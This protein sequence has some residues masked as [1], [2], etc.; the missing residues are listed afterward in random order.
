MIRQY[1]DV[2]FM[3][4]ELMLTDAFRLYKGDSGILVSVKVEKQYYRN[5]KLVS[6]N[7]IELG[8][9][10]RAI[11]RKAQS[12]CPLEDDGIEDPVYCSDIALI[13]EGRLDILI[14]AEAIDETSEMGIYQ[15]QIQL[16]GGI[17]EDLTRPRLTLEPFEFEACDLISEDME[18]EE[19]V[20]DDEYKEATADESMVDLAMVM[21]EEEDEDVFDE[22]GN[23]NPTVWS[24]GMLI[25]SNKLNKMEGAI[26]TINN[27]TKDI[28]EGY[29][30]TEY[31]MNNYPT[32][33]YVQTTYVDKTDFGSTLEELASKEYVNE[34]ISN[35]DIPE[36][37]LS[38]CAPIDHTHPEYITEIPSDYIN[39]EELEA[40]GY[41]TEHQDL[42]GYATNNYVDEKLGDI[43][44]IL[45]S[46]NGEEI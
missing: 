43:E 44:S 29:A 19:P 42:S 9:Y 13:E 45:K 10:G 28:R 26:G 4:G 41:L 40:R 32:K 22:E 27:N 37:D 24:S 21:S 18:L 12:D 15:I 6:E 11:I 17:S 39:E 2:L 5:N 35:I 31:V 36:V 20:F 16:Y 23:Y 46:I 14:P 7:L 34:S 1:V 38:G 25:S 30:T 8:K 3:D 33:D